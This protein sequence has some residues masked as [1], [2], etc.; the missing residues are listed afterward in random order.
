MALTESRDLSLGTTCPDFRLRSVDGKSVARDDFRGKPVLVVLFICNH[1]PYVQAVEERIVQL[2]R[3]YGPRGVQLVGICSNDPTD[4][5]DDRPERLLQRWR[6]KDYGFPYLLDETQDVARAF[7]AVCTPDIYVFDAERRLA[8]H[9]RIDDNWQQPAK[10]KRREL[11]A[12]L[13]ALLAG[14]A[15]TREQQ[16]SIGCSIKWRKA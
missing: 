12:A 14:R 13:D 1:C 4:Y 15:P 6:E 7:N 3:D 16:A 11:A 5:P 2:R 9:G 8:Y 10:V